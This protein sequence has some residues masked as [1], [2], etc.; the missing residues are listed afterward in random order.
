MCLVLVT[1]FIYVNSSKPYSKHQNHPEVG[2]FIMPILQIGKLR[3]KRLS[4][5]PQ[6]NRART[7]R[8]LIQTVWLQSEPLSISPTA[9]LKK[10]DLEVGEAMQA[11]S[12]ARRVLVLT[13]TLFSAAAEPKAATRVISG[14]LGIK[15]PPKPKYKDTKPQPWQQKLAGLYPQSWEWLKG[16]SLCPL[17]QPHPALPLQLPRPCIPP[18]HLASPGRQ[19]QTPHGG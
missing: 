6:G 1:C 9:S 17:C 3:H 2:I 15:I 16:P 4:N 12:R 11:S 8:M 10:G 18:L 5:F 19:P 14:N 7:A 13:L